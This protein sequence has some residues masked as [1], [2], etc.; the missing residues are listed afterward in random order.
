MTRLAAALAALLLALPLGGCWS[1]IELNDR[2]FITSAYLDVGERPGEI[3]LTIGS[4]LPNRLG[5]AGVTETSSTEGKPYTANTQSAETLPEALEKIQNDLTRQLTWSQTRV[6]VIS[7]AY[8]SQVGMQ[9]M[10]EWASR[11]SSIPLRTFI[12]IGEGRARDY[13]N[14]TPVYER[15]PSEVLREFGNRRFVGQAS[16]K[17]LA[18]ASSIGDGIAVPLLQMGSK[19]LVSEYGK[20]SQWAGLAGAA[21]IQ[22]MRMRARLDIDEA[23]SV[24]WA[25][26]KL[27]DPLYNVLSEK[28][29]FDIKLTNLQAKVVPVY[30]GGGI[31]C[32]IRLG[33]EATLESVQSRSEVSRPDILHALERKLNAEIADDLNSALRKS[34]QAGSDVLGFGRRLEWRYPRLWGRIKDR[35][36][37]VY[38]EEVRFDIDSDIRVNHLNAENKPLWTIK[39]QQQ[40]EGETP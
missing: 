30:S 21:M 28:G 35:W 34:Q 16:L 6:I 3:T 31:V 4:P 14:L 1:K 29:K 22:G 24:N 38:G 12:F 5:P 7:E 36:P 20:N 33:A 10:L 25:L 19:P 2:S 9:S 40:G 17:D 23:K 18:V 15:S 27:S 39:Q 11:V 26:G 32:K 13:I 37:L 8:A